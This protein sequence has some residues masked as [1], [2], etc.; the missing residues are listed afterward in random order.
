MGEKLEAPIDKG[1]LVAHP[2]S[3]PFSYFCA[4]FCAVE[5]RSE[6]MCFERAAEGKALGSKGLA[7]AAQNAL[8]QIE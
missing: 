5:V 2:R 4:L 1:A 6:L 7:S 8:M 3:N